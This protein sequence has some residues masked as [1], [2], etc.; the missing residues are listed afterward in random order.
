MIL[1]IVLVIIRSLAQED[2]E[3]LALLANPKLRKGLEEAR[4]D[5]A[6]G[7]VSSLDELTAE[8]QA[9]L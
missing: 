9:K 1:F 3:D 4:A 8:D 5:V 7:R 6:A 2:L